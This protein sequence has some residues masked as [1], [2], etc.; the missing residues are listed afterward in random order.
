MANTKVTLWNLT[1]DEAHLIDQ[2]LDDKEL[3]IAEVTRHYTPC[4]LEA[5]RKKSQS[6]RVKAFAQASSGK[7]GAI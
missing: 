1:K 3:Q 7:E 5:F 2:L 4:D 6:I